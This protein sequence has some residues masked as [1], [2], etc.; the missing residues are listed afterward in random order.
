ML[1]S[2]HGIEHHNRSQRHGRTSRSGAPL[3]KDRTFHERGCN[4]GPW[5]DWAPK[6]IVGTPGTPAFHRFRL[7]EARRGPGALTPPFASAL[8]DRRKTASTGA[9][10]PPQIQICRS[11]RGGGCGTSAAGD[12]VHRDGARSAAPRGSTTSGSSKRLQGASALHR[13]VLG[14]LHNARLYARECKLAPEVGMRQARS[15]RDHASLRTNG[16]NCDC[17]GTRMGGGGGGG[18]QR[19]APR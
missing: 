13:R 19:P 1:S 10:R 18:P 6:R 5:K 14:P 16:S 15:R 2:L 17:P 3:T 8:R 11:C 12:V 9:V 4:G 7:D